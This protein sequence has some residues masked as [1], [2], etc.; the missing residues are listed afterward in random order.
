MTHLLRCAYLKDGAQ[1]HFSSHAILHIPGLG[2]DGLIGYS[3]I[4]LA[5]NAIATGLSCEERL[6]FCVTKRLRLYHSTFANA[7]QR[8]AIL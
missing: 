1:L 4:E 2:Y 8:F 3:P 7:K 5:K 6:C